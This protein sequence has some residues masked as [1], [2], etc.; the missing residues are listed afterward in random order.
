MPTEKAS[1]DDAHI[2][3]FKDSYNLLRDANNKV[4]SA[5]T[6]HKKHDVPSEPLTKDGHPKG[7][8]EEEK[9]E[10]EKLKNDYVARLR[11]YSR[12]I[13]QETHGITR[14]HFNRIADRVESSDWRRRRDVTALHAVL[15]KIGVI[16]K[17]MPRCKTCR[18]F[19]DKERLF[20][21]LFHPA[22][23]A[24]KIHSEG[25]ASEGNVSQLRRKFQRGI[26][27]AHQ[28][29]ERYKGIVDEAAIDRLYNLGSAA[30]WNRPKDINVIYLHGCTLFGMKPSE[31][32]R[33]K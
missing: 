23:D 29:P 14:E 6:I 28:D 12:Y 24:L 17:E 33:K 22:I 4:F 19:G 3:P 11:N 32:L 10:L 9:N 15:N 31:H 20:Y 5:T 30:D 2:G 18:R 8:T 13:E 16:E 7:M 27:S 21:E 1:S 26:S 25:T